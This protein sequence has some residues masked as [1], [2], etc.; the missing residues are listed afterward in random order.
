MFA[1]IEIALSTRSGTLIIPKVAVVEEGKDRAV[2]VVEN[3]QALRKTIITGVEQDD[4]VEVLQGLHEGDRIVTKGQGSL[5]DRSAVR[6]IEE[7]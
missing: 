1:K 7:G 2:F 5:K 3:N 6:V 4:R